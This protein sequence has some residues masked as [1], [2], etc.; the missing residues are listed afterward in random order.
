VGAHSGRGGGVTV[1]TS[2]NES[3][4]G[5]PD[6]LA[7]STLSEELSGLLAGYPNDRLFILWYQPHGHMLAAGAGV[8]WIFSTEPRGVRT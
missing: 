7:P 1:P 4:L 8:G 6:A 5:S 3:P 2:G